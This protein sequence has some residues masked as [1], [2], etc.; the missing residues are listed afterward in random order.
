MS[1]W[2]WGKYPGSARK[3]ELKL[4]AEKRRLINQLPATPCPKGL[5]PIGGDEFCIPDSFLPWEKIFKAIK[6]KLGG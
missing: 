5:E 6:R 2:R 1:L 4:L 3:R